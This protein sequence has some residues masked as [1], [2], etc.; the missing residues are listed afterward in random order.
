[1][2]LGLYIL[3][4][5]LE[6]PEPDIDRWAQWWGHTPNR[7]VK[8]EWVD[9]IWVSTVFLGID[10]N[11]GFSDDNRPLLYETMTFS[12]RRDYDQDMGGRWHTWAE[13]EENHN[14]IVGEI[15]AKYGE[16]GGSFEQT[17][18]KS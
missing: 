18:Q 11:H 1:M 12:N 5:K 14:R 8:Q 6:V 10:H 15:R 9:N 17:E 13:A 4:G 16:G 7:I 2:R 3:D